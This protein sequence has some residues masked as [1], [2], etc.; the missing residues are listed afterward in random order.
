MRPGTN[1]I[2]YHMGNYNNSYFDDDLFLK[3]IGM[4]SLD[5]ESRK[6]LLIPTHK[7]GYIDFRGSRTE[8]VLTVGRK[9]YDI[10][11]M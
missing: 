3:M 6:M 2:S 8:Y 4:R 5:T 1:A 10:T 9:L 7:L 11:G